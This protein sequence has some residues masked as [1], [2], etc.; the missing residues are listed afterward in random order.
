MASSMTTPQPNSFTCFFNLA[1]GSRV[2]VI[3]YP[4][5][6]IDL[7]YG[8][9]IL[10]LRL[11]MPNKTADGMSEFDVVFDDVGVTVVVQLFVT[12]RRRI[13]PVKRIADGGRI[14]T[15]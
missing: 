10:P 7:E 11:A 5:G 12:S 9:Q 13:E 1:I 8:A 6:R 3:A 4:D 14:E 15:F 2:S